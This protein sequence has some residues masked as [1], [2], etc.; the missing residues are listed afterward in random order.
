MTLEVDET[1]RLT[2]TH[3]N[4]TTWVKQKMKC[5]WQSKFHALQDFNLKIFFTGLP[6][7]HH[8][9]DFK[10]ILWGQFWIPMLLASFQ[11]KHEGNV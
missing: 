11:L 10:T 5:G 4:V 1:L 9:H 6:S 8:S 2:N 3:N 7:V